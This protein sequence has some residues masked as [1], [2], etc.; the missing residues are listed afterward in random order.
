MQDRGKDGLRT[1]DYWKEKADQ[2][3]ALADDVSDRSAK[4]AMENIA[5][6]Y[7][8][9]AQRAETRE[10]AACEKSEKKDPP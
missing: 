4:A 2:A 1:S 7:E 8:S 5:L 9:M 10:K 3:R 6:M